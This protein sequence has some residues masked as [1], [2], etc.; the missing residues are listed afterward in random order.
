MTKRRFILLTVL[1]LSSIVIQNAQNIRAQSVSS[2]STLANVAASMAPG[3]FA[4]LNQSGDG[5]G[6]DANL[7]DGSSNCIPVGSIFGYAQKAVYDPITDRVYFS[8][9]SH[10]SS[11]ACTTETIHYDVATNRWAT[12]GNAPIAG[13]A[14]DSNALDPISR[15]LYV[16]AT[17]A[18]NTFHKMDLNSH[19]WSTPALPATL[20][21]YNIAEPSAEY[22]PDRSELLWLQGG[23]AGG[24]G[25]YNAATNT[26]R[27][28]NTTL[29]GLGVRSAIA[30]Y[31]PVCHCVLL[32]GGVGSTADPL[33][34]MRGVYK[35][36]ANGVITRMKDSPPSIV[37]YIND[38]LSAADPVTGNLIVIS[39]VMTNG[40][41]TGQLEFWSYDPVADVWT[42]LN[43]SAIPATAN[44]W[45]QQGNPFGV[46]TTPIN[47]YGVVM[48][49]SA[50]P[51]GSKSKVY[52]YKH[53]TSGGTTWT[54]DTTAPS[55]PTN[56]AAA[57]VSSSQITISWTASTD[58]VGV[59]GYK[60][61]MNGTLAGTTTNTSYQSVGLSASIS[62][63]YTVAA[64][65]AAG[66]T[67]TQTAVVSSTTAVGAVPPP[68][69]TPPPSST[70]TQKCTQPGVLHCFPFDDIAEIRRATWDSTDPILNA[71]MLRRGHTLSGMSWLTRTS[72]EALIVARR[73]AGGAFQIPTI[74]NS[75][76][77]DGGGSLRL[78]TPGQSA[79]AG[80]EYLN[81]FN[82][83]LGNPSPYVS[84]TS[85]LGNV[86]Y[87]QYK[88]RANHAMLENT[89]RSVEA[90]FTPGTP[91]GNIVTS[92]PGAT[93]ITMAPGSGYVA[94]NGF[95]NWTGRDVLITGGGNFVPGFYTITQYID[96]FNL[97]LD[98]SPTPNGAGNGASMTVGS[99]S[100]FGLWNGTLSTGSQSDVIVNP[101]LPADPFNPQMVGKTLFFYNSVMGG[102][103]SPLT[104]TQFIDSTHI[105][106]NTNIG[107][108]LS[109]KSAKIGNITGGWKSSIVVAN[110]PYGD[111]NNELVIN[112]G[113]QAGYPQ[114]YTNKGIGG[115]GTQ[116][117]Q[118]YIAD[119]WQEITQ[120]IELINDAGHS[121]R[122]TMWV[123]GVQVM[124]GTLTGQS[125]L[126]W[127]S[128]YGPGQIYLLTYH[129]QKDPTQQHT[130]GQ[131]WYDDLIVSTQPIAMSGAGSPS[132]TPSPTPSLTPSPTPAPLSISI[133]SPA[134]GSTVSGSSVTVST[135]AS[136][137]GILGVQF[138][139]DGQNLGSEVTS[140]PYSVSWNTTGVANGSHTLTAVVRDA[141]GAQ[142]SPAVSVT[143]TNG[144]TSNPP[145]P[146]TTTGLVAQ[147][148]FDE[149]SGLTAA[150]SVGTNNGALNNGS[151]WQPG[152]VGDDVSLDGASAYVVFNDSPA[153]NPP[154]ITLA[155]W[156]KASTIAA[157]GGMIFSKSDGL[158][159]WLRVEPSAVSM[160]AN[161]N[162]TPTLLTKP[163]SWVS[164]NWYHIAA[165]Y[166]GA[167]M[168]LFVNGVSIGSFGISGQITP[169]AG[170]LNLG[171]RGSSNI[172]YF[173]GEL[174]DVRIYS[175][176]LSAVDVTLLY[177]SSGASG[178]Q[179]G[180]AI[181]PLISITS[182]LPQATLSGATSIAAV[183]SDNVGVA[184][185]QFTVDGGNV[186]AEITTAPYSATWDTRTISNGPHTVTAIARDAAGNV[187][188]NSVSVM[189]SNLTK[190]LP[191]SPPSSDGSTAV[192]IRPNGGQ[193][194]STTSSST[195]PLHVGYAYATMSSAPVSGI[196]IFGFR[197]NGVL[198]TEAGVPASAPVSSGRIYADISGPVNTAIALANTSNQD[199]MISFNFTA[200][201]GQDFGQGSFILQ[202]KHHFSAFL[203][204]AP[205]NGGHSMQGTFS[206][207]SSA[208]VG[209]IA[210]RGFTNQRGEFLI[211]TL[212]V[213]P[214]GELSAQTVVLPHFAAG[215]GWRTEVILSNPLDTPLSGF[216]EFWGTGSPTES[217]V[218]LTMSLNSTTGS[219]FPYSIPPRSAVRLV[220]GSADDIV[221]TGSVRIIP[222]SA[223]PAA[224]AIFS[225][226][227]QGIT[228]SEAGVST[229][230]TGTA[231]RMYVE[232]FGETQQ[233]GSIQSG[234]A[235]A[236]PS[237]N[238]VSVTIE[239]SSLDGASLGDAAT[240]T[241]PANGQVA[242]FISELAPTL[243]AN[244]SGLL[245]VTSSS[246]I[247][248]IGL[249][250]RYNE[251]GDFLM[252]TTPPWNEA[253]LSTS[254]QLVFPHIASGG[255]YTTQ[256][257]IYGKTS[258]GKLWVD[259]ED[260]TV[261]P[262]TSLQP[263]R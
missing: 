198:L 120:R 128:S 108:N 221:Q 216:V 67:S 242:R 111:T 255:G 78:D 211:T 81:N 54:P 27:A 132:P 118:P 41:Y 83:V 156:V 146:T 17:L 223:A 58:N 142:T 144:V 245:R 238:P 153:L 205:F 155:A 64:Y 113:Y 212:P 42:Q 76:F 124:D 46:V 94:A 174:D 188:S 253:E 230:A 35:Y 37:F 13:H 263:I 244:F 21:F 91:T 9:A 217:A 181:P 89:I 232:A 213:T 98:R 92:G 66:N 252:T 148:K 131:V 133:T 251:R 220:T 24:L 243:P 85:P 231:F 62:Y 164:G 224:T 158:Q 97:Q 1:V 196:A 104:V 28:V 8:G 145:P 193:A 44:W 161:I 55:T 31:S 167:R 45:Q 140:S 254:S 262:S 129:T 192:D 206:F 183:A 60:I 130:T 190:E 134:N 86:V 12:D 189:V 75:V 234:M 7:L 61:F 38:S 19:T 112:N 115:I 87:V 179:S 50:D 246:P 160:R 191:D 141:S 99:D 34:Q 235:I 163:Y 207:T 197:P 227:N 18:A 210:V 248:V 143:V 122:F 222:D 218:R 259:T 127:G 208:P 32:M 53:S 185:V 109:G 29:S 236:N 82:G 48:F 201:D 10:A 121:D 106:V 214:I 43:S 2:G 229:Q 40:S 4:L 126:D 150:D 77:T 105:R 241:I 166:D 6:Y 95:Q 261:L 49:M 23:W 68:S 39:S 16:S 123:D 103:Y 256:F 117:T 233:P 147:W 203:D 195:E 20:G 70:F 114:M 136:G 257:L 14:Y 184:S 102:T 225:F 119:Q 149:G 237:P 176:A 249:R 168:E 186:G 169:I 159:Y 11:G 116:Y 88:I 209:V 56:V 170:P 154:T 260:G 239:P 33:A 30:R 3:T 100:G 63:G 90:T 204:Q 175:G 171:R 125:V 228:V 79:A 72:S 240:I 258:S 194:W 139:L 36:D 51:V 26:W 59:V 178:P 219:R 165:T 215:A 200:A 84:P 151:A 202:A 177:N 74:D 110:P 69:T 73:A 187:A 22:F 47:K 247:G 5:S 152:K 80:G 199:A 52:L 71:E 25:S 172:N 65:D 107:T 250:S 15:E 157:G 162:G 182:P 93:T 137:S 173:A 135:S 138:L 226:T 96:Q 101:G 180:D 57:V